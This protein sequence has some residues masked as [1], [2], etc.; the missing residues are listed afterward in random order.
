MLCH[1]R[2]GRG[3]ELDSAHCPSDAHAWSKAGEDE[4]EAESKEDEGEGGSPSGRLALVTSSGGSWLQPA[5]Q[6]AS[7]SVLV[8]G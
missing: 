1:P 2:P 7:T 4:P 3:L 6:P 8:A 5:S